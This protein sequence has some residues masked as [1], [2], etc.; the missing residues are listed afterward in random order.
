M[1]HVGIST[2]RVRV[3]P[4][5][6]PGNDRGERHG[7]ARLRRETLAVEGAGF[8]AAEVGETPRGERVVRAGAAFIVRCGVQER[9][10]KAMCFRS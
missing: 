3:A 4:A 1:C 7:Q 2:T 6:T 8:R 9:R 5:T 10:L